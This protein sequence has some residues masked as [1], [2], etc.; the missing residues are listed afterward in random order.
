VHID[1]VVT[2]TAESVDDVRPKEAR[3]AGDEHAH[4]TYPPSLWTTVWKTGDA[5]WTSERNL[6]R[7]R[8][9]VVGKALVRRRPVL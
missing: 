4:V 2:A 9:P 1:D 7:P 6:G 5:P 3:A 8:I